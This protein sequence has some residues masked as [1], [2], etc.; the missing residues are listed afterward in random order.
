MSTALIQRY[1][2]HKVSLPTALKKKIAR[3]KP[4]PS[5]LSLPEVLKRIFGFIDD[6]TIHDAII[7]VC[8]LWFSIN[9][10]RLFRELTWKDSSKTSSAK[11]L[12]EF[13]SRLHRAK[14]L[15]CTTKYNDHVSPDARK[16]FQALEWINYCKDQSSITDNGGLRAADLTGLVLFILRALPYLPFITIL[17]LCIMQHN[18]IDM[19]HIFQTCPR[20]QSL[21]LDSPSTLYLQGN[22]VGSTPHTKHL[23]LRNLRRQD[24][25]EGYSWNRLYKCLV[26]LALPL[27]SIHFSDLGQQP[28][29]DAQEAQQ[30]VLMICPHATECS[31]WTSNLTPI[32]R[33]CLQSSPMLSRLRTWSQ[34]AST[35]PTRVS[36]CTSSCANRLTSSI[37]KPASRFAWSREWIPLI[38]GCPYPDTERMPTVNQASGWCRQL[39]TLHIEFHNLGPS[40]RQL[41]STRCR[42]LFGYTSRVCPN[43][44]DLEIWE[45]E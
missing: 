40:D 33:Q 34:R 7:L 39:Q 16:I 6:D 17:R 26:S 13:I 27:Q 31:F 1:P 25:G 43:L 20:L 3:S 8:R 32:L 2:L 22:W 21:Q 9:Q 30:N 38:D 28:T 15:K 23:Q 29:D 24:S 18:S 44:R 14:H 11:R 45:P 42:V 19:G 5:A 37:S 10:R 12:N 41:S 35:N 36:P 4:T